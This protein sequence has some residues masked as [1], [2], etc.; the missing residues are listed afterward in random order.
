MWCTTQRKLGKV[1]HR[2]NGAAT[3]V[4]VGF[5]SFFARSFS[6][7]SLASD[8]LQSIH[9]GLELVAMIAGA[10]DDGL[11]VLCGWLRC[12]CWFGL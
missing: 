4:T 6:K 9:P 3:A 12:C 5:S 7:I 2:G 1:L 11:F 10:L 8:Y